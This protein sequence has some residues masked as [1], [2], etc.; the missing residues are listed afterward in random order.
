[1][2]WKWSYR[3]QLRPDSCGFSTMVRAPSSNLR[4][5]ESRK[6]SILSTR[7]TCKPS[8]TIATSQCQSTTHQRKTVENIGTLRLSKN[9]RQLHETFRIKVLTQNDLVRSA[10]KNAAL[11][12]NLCISCAHQVIDSN[13]SAKTLCV[14]TA[15]LTNTTNNHAHRKN[16]VRFAVD[17]TTQLFMIL[18]SPTASFST[19]VVFGRTLTASSCSK[20][21]SQNPNT[22]SQQ[23]SQ[24][25]KAPNSRY[26]QTFNNQSQQNVQRR[27]S[28]GNANNQSS[29]FNQCSEKPKNL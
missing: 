22:S 18:P 19:E 3:V 12:H 9:N 5:S 11:T 20:A 26:G 16:D 25:N 7:T 27:N 29:S 15:C 28:N 17:S 13:F 10:N 2:D 23:K 21:S 6:Q 1:M 8:H 4:Q 24:T 14:Q